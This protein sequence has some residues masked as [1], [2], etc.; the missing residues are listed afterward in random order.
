MVTMVS[1][2]AQRK[3]RPQCWELKGSFEIFP[4]NA[5]VTTS[6]S[7]VA[8]GLRRGCP[9][10]LHISSGYTE[11]FDF[12]SPYGK[13][14]ECFCRISCCVLWALR[15]WFS[16]WLTRS[17]LIRVWWRT[18]PSQSWARKRAH[19]GWAWVVGYI[20]SVIN[21]LG[22]RS[23]RAVVLRVVRFCSVQCRVL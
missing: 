14:S 4:L 20:D 2:W 18:R 6:P 5:S 9:D 23:R 8:P 15:D 10:R 3:F 1:M 16:L 17:E 7:D 22:W 19:E 21:V 12:A 13:F 11:G